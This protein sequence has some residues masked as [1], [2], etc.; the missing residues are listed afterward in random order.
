MVS[1]FLSPSL[2]TKTGDLASLHLRRDQSLPTILSTQVANASEQGYAEG[3]VT[4]TR[5]GSFPHST[6]INVPWGSQVR[7]S[8]V[9]TGSRGRTTKSHKKRKIDDDEPHSVSTPGESAQV[10]QAEVAES[11]FIHVLPPTPENWTTSLPHR[12]QV[13]YTPDYSYILHRI[14][15]RPGSR[16]IE[17]GSG[18]GSFTHAA[19]RAVF[20][21]Y[22][23]G[24]KAGKNETDTDG[25]QALKSEVEARRGESEPDD[26]RGRVFTY[27]FHQE[28]HEKV[29]A[30]MELHGLDAIVHAMH[31]DVYRDGFL[32]YDADQQ[33]VPTSPRA[34]AVFLDLPAPWEA[35]PHLTRQGGAD[36]APSVLDPEST[37]HICTFSPCIEQAQKTVSALRRHDWVDIEMVEMQH[38]RVEVR[39]E[40]TGLHY[41][42]MRGVNVYGA[43]VDEAVSRL[44]EVEQRLKDFHA[45]KASGKRKQNHRQP[46]PP[47]RLPLDEGRLVHRTEP[48]LKTHTS[49]LVFAILPRAWTE[50]DETA[51]QEKWAKNVTV[52]T[53]APK[54]Q[55][56]LKKQAK[57]ARQAKQRLKARG[58][59]GDG[60]SEAS[61]RE[62]REEINQGQQAAE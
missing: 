46:E 37:V 23:R 25:V 7:A 19:A 44:R 24:R 17:A 33:T 36:G 47:S 39:R 8:K 41:D 48:E 14:R 42:G 16:L 13:V 59:T 3:V 9:D 2:H 26:A 21:G 53:N 62:E 50:E 30:E 11:G 22:G 51:A 5:F 55:R 38:K 10:K 12:T 32:L 45:G 40:Y 18:S 1:T 57:Q 52:A 15:A 60:T 28:R 4:N 49:Y 54:S 29:K 20:S 61:R 6:I 35:L 27:E 31:R 34:N 58:Q 56:Q 43:D